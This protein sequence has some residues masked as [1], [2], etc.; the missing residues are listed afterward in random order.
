MWILSLAQVLRSTGTELFVPDPGVFE[1]LYSNI[2]LDI[3]HVYPKF[4]LLGVITKLC[5]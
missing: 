1:E 2:T 4:I 5:A 3:V